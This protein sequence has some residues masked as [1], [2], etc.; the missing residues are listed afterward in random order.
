MREQKTVPNYIGKTRTG[1][2]ARGVGY[3][4]R[5]GWINPDNRKNMKAAGFQTA[6]EI[7]KESMRR[8]A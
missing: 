5:E 4:I 3:S 7:L 6:K 2:I 1:R 8:Y